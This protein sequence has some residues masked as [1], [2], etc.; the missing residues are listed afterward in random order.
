MAHVF[1][2]STYILYLN[3]FRIQRHVS[4]TPKIKVTLF[5]FFP[6]CVAGKMKF[7]SGLWAHENGAMINIIWQLSPLAFSTTVTS[8]L[9]V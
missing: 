3:D 4:Q 1:H 5:L 8:V 7:F 2:S 6:E 9:G